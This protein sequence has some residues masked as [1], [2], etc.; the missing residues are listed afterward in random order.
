M[1]CRIEGAIAKLRQAFALEPTSEVDPEVE[2]QQ[3]LAE[4][5]VERGEVLARDGDIEG[6]IAKF[7]EALE[8]DPSF[9]IKPHSWN[10]LCWLGSLS[11]HAADVIDACE[12]AVELAPN[13]G[14]IR[15]SRGFARALTGDYAGAIEDFEFY[16]EWSKE[17]ERYERYGSKRE[18]WIAELEAGRNPFDAE[19]L[20]ALRN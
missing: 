9:P 1:L 13:E 14:W 20:E 6:A 11:G 2:I 17:N 8:L 16:V 18:P 15:D 10:T 19:T 5:L 12:R 4:A 3:L 7:Q